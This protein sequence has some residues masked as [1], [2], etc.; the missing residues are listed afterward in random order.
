[1]NIFSLSGRDIWIIG[2]A[3]YLGTATVELA[4]AAGAKV[5]CVDRGPRAADMVASRQLESSVTPV[6][7]D[8]S[9]CAAVADFLKT[10]LATRGVPDGLVVMTYKTT[11]KAMADL[12]AED[13]D[14]VNRTG[15]TSTFVMVREV[16]EAM[17]AKGRG[18]IVLFSSMYGTIA[19]DPQ[20]YPAPINPNPI[21]YGV[22]KAGIQQM[23]R[24]FAVH[25]G[26]QGVRCNS[27]APG[28][29]PFPS[30]Q[31]D[32][33]EFMRNLAAKTPLGRIGQPK[34]IAGTVVFLVSDAA[35]YVTG[36]NL[37]VDGGW[38]AW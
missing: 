16:G 8:A 32:S 2:G 19:P 28:P 34:E 3:G 12:T 31:E 1:M 10:Q 27:I 17:A 20:V 35:S 11:G 30:Q 9:D 14:G 29:F 5:L 23:A 25:Y 26:R 22:G 13:F 15:L 36:H 21:E 7:L 4:V 18:S 37:A 6:D 38:T 33:P 24:Y